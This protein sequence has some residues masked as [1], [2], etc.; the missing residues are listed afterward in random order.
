MGLSLQL[1]SRR[2]SSSPRPSPSASPSRLR[3]ELM[4]LL[5]DSPEIPRFLNVLLL[6]CRRLP[7]LG[8]RSPSEGRGC[9]LSFSSTDSSW[10]ASRGPDSPR[11]LAPSRSW[12]PQGRLETAGFST[13][14]PLALLLRP[15]SARPSSTNWLEW[16]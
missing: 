5:C 8:G 1:A 9:L 4:G 6:R 7:L 14:E 13:S 15:L 3:L 10:V 2:G 12:L 11:R 16:G